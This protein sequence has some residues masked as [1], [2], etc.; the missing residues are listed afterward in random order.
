[1]KRIAIVTLYNENNFGNRLQNYAVHQYLTQMGFACETL[2]FEKKRSVKFML[3]KQIKQFLYHFIVRNDEMNR[4]ISFEHFSNRYIPKRR[5]TTG[6]STE[7]LAKEYDYYVVGSDQ[8]WNPCFGDFDSLFDQ[9]F[10]TFVPAH[11]RICFSPS[12]G[13]SKIPAEWEAR[14]A[15]ALSG[16]H[17]L[18]AREDEGVRIIKELTGKDA[19][20]L[21][22]P[23]M[24][25]DAE[26]WLKAA[27]K[28]KEENYIL[29]YFLG[30]YPHEA[31]PSNKRIINL[32]DKT[33]GNYYRYNPSDFI[34]LIANADAVYTDSFHACVFSILFNKPFCVME[35]KDNNTVMSSRL[36]S[37]LAMFD[38]SFEAAASSLIHIDAKKRNRVLQVERKKVKRFICAQINTEDD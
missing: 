3:K 10:L 5:I 24:L 18:C 27:R 2:V 6:Y 12:F 32:L 8:V 38:I 15:D 37:L 30:N 4:I 9:M 21:I 35:R 11:K 7:K 20:R 1:M 31:L 33:N 13:V 14:F 22:D 25:F 34:G 19:V 23:T 28:T 29:T 36:Q 26:Q 16:F 17:Q